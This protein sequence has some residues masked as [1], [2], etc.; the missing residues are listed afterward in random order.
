MQ[1]QEGVLLSLTPAFNFNFEIGIIQ[2]K[3]NL[4]QGTIK[5]TIS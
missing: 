4:I 5:E 2:A 1:S 3:I